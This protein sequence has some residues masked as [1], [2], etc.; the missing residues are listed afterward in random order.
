M[1]TDL[2]HRKYQENVPLGYAAARPLVP[3]RWPGLGRRPPAGARP[4]PGFRPDINGAE[5]AAAHSL[6]AVDRV[7]QP[8]PAAVE[9]EGNPV[10]AALG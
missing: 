7:E 1:F 9:G 3:G 5:E 2:K 4:R 6:P 10:T 8:V